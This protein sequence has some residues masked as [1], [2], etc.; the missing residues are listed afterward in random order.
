[1]SENEPKPL[2]ALTDEES[3]RALLAAQGT[4]TILSCEDRLTLVE[5][6]NT[7]LAERDRR[8][9]ELEDG[10]GESWKFLWKEYALADDST[11]TPG[12]IELKHKMREVVGIDR[13]EAELV[14]LR[15][16]VDRLPL[17]RDG[18]RLVPGDYAYHPEW[19]VY[20]APLEVCQLGH[21]MLD[22]LQR[23][24]DE[25]YPTN[26]EMPGFIACGCYSENDT[27]YYEADAF[28]V[29]ECYSSVAALR[30]S[31]PEAA[32]PEGGGE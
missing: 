31:K 15:G 24:Y 29:D 20:S 14:R 9:E 25:R 22:G 30:E 10:F 5:L 19:D 17:T 4:G 16:V 27:G 26:E 1:M 2:T 11:L 7:T 28:H 21:P 32:M 3:M 13:L 8:I 12:A 18:V 6:V 23:E